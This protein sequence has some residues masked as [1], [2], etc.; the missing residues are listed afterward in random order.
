VHTTQ[1]EIREPRFG[2]F[3]PVLQAV[4]AE[5]DAWG[6][7]GGRSIFKIAGVCGRTGQASREADFARR[8][9]YQAVLLSLGALREENLADL[10]T[11]CREIA[12]ISPL[13]G[14]Y[15]QPAV[16]GRALPYAFWRAFAEIEN[17]L[18]IKIAPFN[19]YQTLDV[20][21]AVCDAG[22]AT[23]IALYTGNDDNIVI[24]LLTRFEVR[25]SSGKQTARM[26]GGLLG[27]WAVW[28][29][30]AV[31]LLSEIHQLVQTGLP[32]PPD[33]LTLAAQLTEANAAIFDAANQFA[34]CIPGIHY[35]LHRQG[36]L[37]GA[38]CL[39]PAEVL[40]PG[41]EEAI[42]RVCQAYPALRD[43]DFVQA[44]LATWLS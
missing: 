16:G 8:C 40:S 13:I 26:V 5:I 15:L 22:R 36:L 6:A 4:S 35:V 33:L 2:L 1:F 12:Q 23:D 25:T 41:Q 18:A 3:E 10:I 9:G 38:W 39:N 32:I 14:F 28:T 34:G 37:A 30:N 17:V 43:D 21:R 44:N 7:K 27:Q 19:R 11:H 42:E 29:Q 31:S 24:D 20:I